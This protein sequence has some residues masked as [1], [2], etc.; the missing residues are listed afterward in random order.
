MEVK[1]NADVIRSMTNDELSDF[2]EE[3]EVG[4]IDYAETFCNLCE[5]YAREH[6]RSV[7]CCGCLKWWLEL[8]AKQH[9]QG[10]EYWKQITD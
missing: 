1:T 5:K 3:F 8:P 9:P 7:D 4:D 10:L 6:S 2:L